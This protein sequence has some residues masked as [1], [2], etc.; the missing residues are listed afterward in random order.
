MKEKL[1]KDNFCE[2][3]VKYIFGPYQRG[4]VK[5]T[6]ISYFE[7]LLFPGLTINQIWNKEYLK[8]NYLGELS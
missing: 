6:P 5:Y 8:N 2:L 7:K 1:E 3:M 4:A